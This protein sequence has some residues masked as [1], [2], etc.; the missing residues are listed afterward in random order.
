MV[1]LKSQYES[2]KS[3]IDQAVLECIAST[4]FI[5][6]PQVKDF[7]QSLE[8]YLEIKNVIP[9]ANGTDAL[10]IALM[11]LDL[12][13]GDEI[14]VPSFTY[15]ATAEVIALLKLQ[16]VMVEVDENT[17]NLTAEIIEQAITPKTKAVV[18]V[19]LFGQSCDMSPIMEVAEK[20]N[21]F[22]IEDN[23]QAIGADYISLTATVEKRLEQSV[24]SDARRFF[25]Q[26]ISA[27][28]ATAARFLPMMTNWQTRFG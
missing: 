27:V 7:Q 28:T 12:K 18:P 5:N 22:V 21:L 10:Q 2:I 14:I 26:K 19:H 11:A 1:D 13:A 6:G 23:A 3:E 16:P 24:I 9:C 17:F 20:H 4:S 15:V 25:L 8:N